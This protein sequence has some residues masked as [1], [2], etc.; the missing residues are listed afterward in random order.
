[1]ANPPLGNNFI[2]GP[3]GVVLLTFN[4]VPL[5]KTTD[6]TNLEFIEDMKEIKYAQDGT[7]PADKIPTGQLYRLTAKLAQPTWARLK[8]VLRGITLGDNVNNAKLGRDI[9]RSGFDSFAKSLVVARVDSDGAASTDPKHCLTFFKALP[10]VNGSIGA[11]GP[12]TQRSVEVVFDCFYDE[13]T[14]HECFGYSGVA[15]SLGIS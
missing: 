14:G 7:Q 9:Y 15:S 2:E 10:T 6:E 11:F 3:L 13:S 5:G 1:M 4:S 12:D 8:E